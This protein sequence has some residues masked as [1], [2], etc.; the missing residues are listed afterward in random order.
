MRVLAASTVNFGEE[1]LPRLMEVSWVVKRALVLVRVT[2]MPV[3][4]TR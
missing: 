2:F 3:H 1:A 4:N